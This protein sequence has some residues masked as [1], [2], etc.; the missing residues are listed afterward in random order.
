M[1]LQKT[2]G[3]ALSLLLAAALT[4]NV[5]A[6]GADQGAY[7]LM[8]IPYAE[9]YAAELGAGDAAVDA[10]TSAT[11]N[12]TRTATLA[13]GS[14]HVN[15]DGTDTT[16]VTYPVYVEDLSL[17]AGYNE[18]TDA[19]SVEITV[20][21]RGK[22][23]TTVFEGKEALFEAPSYSYYVLSDTPDCYKTLSADGKF[24]AV[25]GTVS[26]VDGVTAALTVGG[27]H[28]D[29][30]ISLEGTTGIEKGD[31]VNAV[32]LTT[33]D[34]A[35]T[36][37]RHVVNIWR[38]TE[39]GWNIGELDLGGKTVTNVRYITDSAVIDYPVA[40][41]I[42]EAGYVLMNIPYA[43]FY[44]AELG[45]EDA[46]V[47]AVTSATKNKSRTATLAGGSY[48]VNAD[49][50]DISGIV[51]PVF[52]KDLSVL[53]ACKEITDASSVEI[54]VTNRGQ[55]FTSVYEGKEAL[56]EAPSYSYY[57]LTEKPARSKALDA[58]D[59]KFTFGAVG[60][61]AATVEGVTAEVSYGGHHTDVEI[62]LAGTE[63][64]EKGDSVNA[65]ILTTADG[66]KIGLR[67]V[68]N[69][70]RGTELG[71]NYD[72]LALLGKT[73]TNIRYITDSAV[74]DYPVSVSLKQGASKADG[75]IAALKVFTID[76]LPADIENPVV[77]VY[78]VVGE[79]RNAVKEYIVE[80]AP[81]VNGKAT[82]TAPAEY[83]VTYSYVVTSGNYVPL[84][85][86]AESNIPLWNNIARRGLFGL[87]FGGR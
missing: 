73:I 49:G 30:E 41:E 48:H 75:R 76:A 59:G 40:I 26:A 64:I 45:A 53:D 35:K 14:Y 86:T 58:A 77:S 60:G 52:V 43:D 42:P 28:T 74:I 10:V 37:L 15:A 62:S 9:F 79:G 87:F 70:W 3:L 47:D 22:T 32:V 29:I 27:H 44:K 2:M 17:L 1:K 69:I 33:S 23:S 11:K 68:V 82:L 50:T 84:N 31:A 80:N 56:F 13:G 39:L 36:G 25:Q 7:V 57:K 55:T 46:A 81:I 85:G 4:P 5:M 34:G 38:G 71:W 54:T 63:G 51:Y 66:A 61:R 72:E 8:N 83:G 21:N 19:S 78:K 67:H 16:G 18:V 6:D 20:T 24:S 65:V 12:K